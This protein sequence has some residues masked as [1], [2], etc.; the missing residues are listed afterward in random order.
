MSEVKKEI[1]GRIAF[2]YIL[3]GAFSLVIIFQIIKLQ[4]FERDVL[5]KQMYKSTYKKVIIPAIRGDI[6]SSDNKILA[7]SIPYYDIYIDFRANGLTKE[8]FLKNLDSL[9]ICL[10]KLFPEKSK[11]E[12]KQILLRGYNRGYRYFNL[13]KKISFDH[14]KLLKNF[15]LFRLGQ[16]KS[17]FIAE[18]K[19][20]R[21]KLFGDLASRTVGY[22]TANNI[23]VGL[24][25]ACNSYL[26]GKNG[27]KLL[28]KLPG[29]IWVPVSSENNIE[30]QDGF[31]VVTTI[32]LDIQDIANEALYKALEL[33]NADYGCAIVME[34][35]TGKIKAIV[36]LEK[37]TIS[38]AYTEKYNYAIGQRIEPGSTFKLFSLMCA[39]EEGVVKITDTINTGNG[40]INYFGIKMKDS[41]EGGY[42]KI[43]VAE[44]FAY[45]SNVGI[46]KIIYD[47]FAQNPKQFISRLYAIKLHEKL[48]LDIKGEATPLIK[49]PSDTT[50]YGTSLPWISIG[51][52][53]K[54]TPLQILSYY[55]AIANDG[56]LMKP[57]LIEYLKHKNTII[58][59]FEP[60][61]LIPSICSENTLTDLKYM[62]ELVVEKGTAKNIQSKLYKIAGK[63]GTAQIAKG[64]FGYKDNNSRK[65]YISSFVG[66]FPADNPRYSCYVMI[67]NPQKEYYGA[68][69]AAPVFKEIADNIYF[70]KIEFYENF[71]TNKM[72]NY[73]SLFT[74]VNFDDMLK[75]KKF[76]N[77]SINQQ[78]P[79]QFAI[80]NCKNNKIIAKPFQIKENKMPDVRGMNIKDALFIL[81]NMGLE[82]KFRGSGEIINQIPLPNM[83]VNKNDIV[84]LELKY[85]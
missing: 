80:V 27:I 44:V 2:V 52:E 78:I 82:V 71:S 76:F 29:N 20:Y 13:F 67:S 7:T 21:S 55:N 68:L 38:G 83:P 22:T 4:F 63:T 10:S 30:P 79:T 84:Y 46:S 64:K 40:E 42:G 47:N 70:S 33:N 3:M 57:L 53:I 60:T 1:L 36:N 43:S 39:L 66:Y 54:L 6:I 49:D 34:V 25:G 11:N 74:K 26:R 31:D 72:L 12:Y 45:S 5:L 24:E 73:I 69:V 19:Y 41:K 23:N 58:K 85:L 59:K 51:Y 8:L 75:L 35:K 77:L 15:P 56:S 50:W 9:S 16:N 32:D 62:L 17:G 18:K 14:Y 37:D 65:S 61:V 48:G 28:Q 81:N